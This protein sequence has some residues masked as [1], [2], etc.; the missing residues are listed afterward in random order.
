MCIMQEEGGEHITSFYIVPICFGYL[1]SYFEGLKKNPLGIERI[2]RF[3]WK[4]GCLPIKSMQHSLFTF[5]GGFGEQGT[6]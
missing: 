2:W 5:P 6:A 4:I 1:A 3:V